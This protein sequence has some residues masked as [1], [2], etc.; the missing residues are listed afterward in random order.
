MGR[1]WSCW[2]ADSTGMDFEEGHDYMYAVDT[3]IG[4][5]WI[6]KLNMSDP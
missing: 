4:L 3:Y 2:R 1:A 6:D 5:P